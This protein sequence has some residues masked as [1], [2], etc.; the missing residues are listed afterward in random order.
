MRIAGAK[1]GKRECG[2]DGA[3]NLGCVAVGR[4]PTFPIR[5]SDGA[6]PFGGSMVA[7]SRQNPRGSGRCRKR[8]VNLFASLVWQLASDLGRG[9][10]VLAIKWNLLCGRATVLHRGRGFVPWRPLYAL[11]A[12]GGKLR[13]PERFLIEGPSAIV[14]PS[15]G[16]GSG[17][18]RA[19]PGLR[20]SQTRTVRPF[21]G[22]DF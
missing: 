11:A 19:H 8:L 3:G 20:G 22:V 18:S 7:E 12:W 6:F 9:G 13:I 14:T 21:S 4:H 10:A 15:L 5:F 17:W 16:S 2:H 1:A